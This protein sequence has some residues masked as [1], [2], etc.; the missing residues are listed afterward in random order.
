MIGYSTAFASWVK[1]MHKAGG[2]HLCPSP[3]PFQGALSLLV[4]PVVSD[5]ARSVAACVRARALAC[6]PRSECA[7]M[8]LVPGWPGPSIPVFVL[9]AGG[10]GSSGEGSGLCCGGV[11]QGC[12]PWCC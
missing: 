9:V 4:C 3:D 7:L 11:S 6:Q 10:R 8:L 2:V 5:E 1:G 12:H